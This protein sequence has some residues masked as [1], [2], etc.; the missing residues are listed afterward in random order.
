M[1][2]QVSTQSDVG[3]QRAMI[4][5]IGPSHPSR[6]PCQERRVSLAAGKSNAELE[7]VFLQQGA[8]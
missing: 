1:I 8:S 4:K 3:Q 6:P 5:L 2:L 7:P